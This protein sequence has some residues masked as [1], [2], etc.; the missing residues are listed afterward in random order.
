M[1]V[2]AKVILA[3]SDSADC[4]GDMHIVARSYSDTLVSVAVIDKKCNRVSLIDDK[5]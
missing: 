4:R 2:D 3:Q 1:T 5:Q